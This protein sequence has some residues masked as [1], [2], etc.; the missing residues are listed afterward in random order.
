MH[1]ADSS[2]LRNTHTSGI[3]KQ[4]WPHESQR[5]LDVR[6]DATDLFLCYPKSLLFSQNNTVQAKGIW[7]K[8]FALAWASL[9]SSSVD[10]W[11]PIRCIHYYYHKM[12]RHH[13]KCVRTLNMCLKFSPS[14]I[15]MS[16]S[17][18]LC[19]SLALLPLQSVENALFS[20][21]SPSISCSPNLFSC[22]RFSP[23]LSLSPLLTL[24]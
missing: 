3:Q 8:V 22:P 13:C 20:L 1:C 9:D 2:W 18:F 24:F 15:P 12:S 14:T 16:I 10:K 5:I 21:L 23:C 6:D 17:L 19:S 7:F 11:V 4:Q